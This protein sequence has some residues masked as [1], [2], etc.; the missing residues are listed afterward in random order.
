MAGAQ[1][2]DAKRAITP[3]AGDVT[4]G[5][6]YMEK[7]RAAVLAELRA[8]KSAADIEK[9]VLMEAYKDWGSYKQWRALNVR[10][11]AR[12]LTESGAVNQ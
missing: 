10:G 8:G 6:V 11:M 9:N 3:L 1:A 12:F 2:Q 5:R 4:L 7:L